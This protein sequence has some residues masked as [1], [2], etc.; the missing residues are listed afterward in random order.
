MAIIIRWKRW[1]VLDVYQKEEVTHLPVY[2]TVAAVAPQPEKGRTVAIDISPLLLLSISLSLSSQV[3]FM[4]IHS[5]QVRQERRRKEIC[6]SGKWLK[7]R[8][9]GINTHGK[10]K[11]K[12]FVLVFFLSPPIEMFFFFE[13]EKVANLARR[14]ATCARASFTRDS[15]FLAGSF[16]SV[17]SAITI[18]RVARERE[19]EKGVLLAFCLPVGYIPRESWAGKWFFNGARAT[20]RPHLTSSW[21]SPV[22]AAAASA[23]LTFFWFFSFLLFSF[24][25]PALLLL[26]RSVARSA[27]DRGSNPV[28][29]KTKKEK[30]RHDTFVA[31]SF[32]WIPACRTSPHED[33]RTRVGFDR[34]EI[35]AVALLSHH[36]ERDWAWFCRVNRA[37]QPR[38]RSQRRIE[39]GERR[40]ALHPTPST[41]N[42]SRVWPPSTTPVV[43]YRGPPPFFFFFDLLLPSSPPRRR[44]LS[45]FFLNVERDSKLLLF[46]FQMIF[47][48]T[49]PPT[50]SRVRPTAAG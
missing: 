32:S 8:L 15:H 7:S 5:R 17:S 3:A 24:F 4:Y 11:Y 33:G 22:A 19:R 27:P 2:R 42:G 35:S 16:L 38:S 23:R 34:Q 39:H 12:N 43:S 28:A 41:S 29:Q 18:F 37:N 30:R 40:V 45:F 14:G 6:N 21:S 36:R 20:S 46:P 49:N 1:Q 10:M 25:P 44:R 9:D 31:L 48:T 13:K 47:T 50:R 26:R